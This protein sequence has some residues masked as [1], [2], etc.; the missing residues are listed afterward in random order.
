MTAITDAHD[1]M[2][3]IGAASCTTKVWTQMR[4]LKRTLEAW[5]AS[6]AEGHASLSIELHAKSLNPVLPTPTLHKMTERV[7]YLCERF[8]AS[9]ADKEAYPQAEVD[10][11]AECLRRSLFLELDRIRDFNGSL[12][13]EK[14]LDLWEALQR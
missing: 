14:L 5:D 3:R 12:P 10:E 4:D 8:L 11:I 2:A 6:L 9:L 7:A 13:D 1:F